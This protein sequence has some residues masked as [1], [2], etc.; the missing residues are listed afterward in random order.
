MYKIYKIIT[1][2]I[3][4]VLLKLKEHIYVLFLKGMKGKGLKIEKSFDQLRILKK[5]K[6]NEISK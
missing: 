2:L 3:M 1:I 4:F 6:Y 5:T